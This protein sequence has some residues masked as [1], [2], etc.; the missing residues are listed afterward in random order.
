MAK[1]RSRSKSQTRSTKTR[2]TVR[3][4]SRRSGSSKRYTTK[5]GRA[6]KYTSK[7]QSYNKCVSKYVKH[8]QHKRKHG[9]LK[10]RGGKTITNP[11]QAIAIGLSI[12]RKACGRKAS[13]L[14]SKD[15]NN[16]NKKCLIR[17]HPG[18]GLS[19]KMTRSQIM[20]A[21]RK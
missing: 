12:G 6:S 7:R 3:R 17:M 8:E 2:R 10:N 5:R 4:S 14:K 9:S 15:L 18:R 20:R 16:C 1:R 11:R 19:M 21:I 13:G